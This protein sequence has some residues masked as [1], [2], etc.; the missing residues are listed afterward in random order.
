MLVVRNTRGQFSSL[1]ACAA[2][3][4]RDRNVLVNRPRRRLAD[5]HQLQDSGGMPAAHRLPGK[6]YDRDIVNQAL[7]LSNTTSH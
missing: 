7:Q 1:C 2:E 6:G 5:I 4:T 3:N